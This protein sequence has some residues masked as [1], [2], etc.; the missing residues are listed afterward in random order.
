MSLPRSEPEPTSESLGVA[1]LTISDTRTLETDRSGQYLLEQVQT[2]GHRII[3]RQI[4]KDDRYS[5]RAIVSGWIA[6]DSIQVIL[7]TGGTGIAPRDLTPEAIEPLLDQKLP[8]FGEL[9][10]WVS[11]EEIGNAALQSRAFAGVANRTLILSLPGSTGAC[12]TGWEKII[13]SQLKTNPQ[14]CT[15]V[16]LLW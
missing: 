9:F 15:F 11:Y 8:G 1:I 10:R 7:T 6:L 2:E 5:I 12:R 13:R 4:T 14:S 3:D 16:S